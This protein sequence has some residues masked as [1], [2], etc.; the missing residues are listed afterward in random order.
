MEVSKKHGFGTRA[1]HDG[2][3]P[4]P[5]TGAVMPAIYMS[6]TFAQNV[7]EKPKYEYARSNNPTREKLEANLASLEGA[8][9]G[10]AF[11]SGCAALSA[12]LMTLKAGDHVLCCDDVYGGTHRLLT[13]VYNNFNIE[14]TF[15]DGTKPEELK[16][17]LKQNSRMLLLESPT[18]PALTIYDINTLSSLAHDAGLLVVTDN[19]FASPYLQNPL[20][21]GSDIVLHSTTK[22]IGGHSDVVGG[23]LC[24]NGDETYKRLKHIQNSAGAVPSPFDCF[25]T[26]RGIKTLHVRMERHCRNAMMIAEHLSSHEEVELVRYPGLES[27]PQHELAKKQMKGFGGMVTF[28]LKGGYDRNLKFVKNL[29]LI[30][31]GESLGGVESLIAHPFTMTHVSVPKDELRKRG[32]TDAILRLSTGIED[33]DDLIGD[34]EQAI[35]KSGTGTATAF[36]DGAGT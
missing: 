31:F 21:L 22:Y 17:H 2:Q 27:H 5:L 7:S 13:Q 23:A 29:E 6:S 34:I 10:I 25:I 8:K 18:N 36:R 14:V 28:A 15:F 4:C 20:Q 16:K 24:L 1:I 35:R 33:V 3:P 19:T 26:M 12:C 32:I 11:S 9:Y 30:H